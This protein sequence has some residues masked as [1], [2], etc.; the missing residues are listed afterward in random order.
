MLHF[1]ID[2]MSYSSGFSTPNSIVPRGFLNADGLA[3]FQEIWARA[4]YL[5]ELC[6]PFD[7][8]PRGVTFPLTRTWTLESGTLPARID[9]TR[10]A[11][12]TPDKEYTLLD[13]EGRPFEHGTVV[14][15]LTASPSLIDLRSRSGSIRRGHY[16]IV[17]D[18]MR[19]ALGAPGA[20]RPGNLDQGA[21]YRT[22]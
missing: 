15:E 1:Q 14:V 7:D 17:G 8:N 20:P 13:A 18:V 2:D 6:E 10:V 4:A 5:D 3:L 12:N 11:V 21:L 22:R 9:F 19:L 16:D